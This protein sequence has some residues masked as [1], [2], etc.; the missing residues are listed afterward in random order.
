MPAH[1]S[2]S[3]QEG[4][5]PFAF[6]FK[7][8]RARHRPTF[9]SGPREAAATLAAGSSRKTD[10]V[11]PGR[12]AASPRRRKLA[13]PAQNFSQLLPE[14]ARREPPD[15]VYSINPAA[16]FAW[17]GA[18]GLAGATPVAPFS[19]LAPPG[20]PL[21]PFSAQSPAGSSSAKRRL[22]PHRRPCLSARRESRGD[23][24][25]GNPSSWRKVGS[26]ASKR[27]KSSLAGC[28]AAQ[29]SLCGESRAPARPQP[30]MGPP[31]SGGSRGC[32]DLAL[33]PGL[34]VSSL[35]GG[36]LGW[37]CWALHFPLVLVRLMA[38]SYYI[39]FVFSSKFKYNVNLA[40]DRHRH[41]IL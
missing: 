7:T 10:P 37:G 1:P 38:T 4:S 34:E 3:S 19:V 40:L 6:A 36:M 25:L 16:Q 31:G 22:P 12:S 13:C 23:W 18:P 32:G 15:S 33:L 39:A 5:A 21:L 2:L 8:S 17:R 30:G 9:P 35:A 26:P 20:R 24:D 28:P 14:G 41:K 29:R 27:G 11:D